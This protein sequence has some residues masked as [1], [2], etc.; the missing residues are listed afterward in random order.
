MRSSRYSPVWIT[1]SLVC[2]VGIT[3]IRTVAFVRPTLGPPIITIAHDRD[4]PLVVPP[5]GR[6]PFIF[7]IIL[8][9]TDLVRASPSPNSRYPF[10]VTSWYVSRFFVCFSRLVVYQRQISSSFSG[11]TALAI[12]LRSSS[13]SGSFPV[14]EFEVFSPFARRVVGSLMLSP[15]CS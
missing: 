14:L 1:I 5:L 2:L 7:S 3:F 6:V 15:D 4:S 11:V 10:V 12:I 13:I 8:F 9:V